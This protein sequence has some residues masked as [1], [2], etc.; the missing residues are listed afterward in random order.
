MW[1]SEDEQRQQPGLLPA[2]QLTAIKYACAL[3]PKFTNV[4]QWLACGF[5]Y[6]G[7]S[8]CGKRWKDICNLRNGARNPRT[9]LTSRPSIGKRHLLSVGEPSSL[10]SV[11]SPKVLY[12]FAL[13]DET[14]QLDCFFPC[15]LSNIYRIEE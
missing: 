6:Q 12:N 3:L 11:A 7:W 13:P 14:I 5:L 9:A 1:R 2:P 8:R 15:N 4:T 10:A